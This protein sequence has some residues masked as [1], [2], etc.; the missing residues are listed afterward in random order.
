[1][2]NLN[3]LLILTMLFLF[4]ATLTS[5]V[6]D[7]ITVEGAIRKYLLYV[8]PSYTEGNDDEWP[9][10]LNLHF[11]R[12]N[13]PSQALLTRMHFLADTAKFI[14]V[15]P[16]GEQIDISDYT[17]SE[18]PQG[19]GWNLGGLFSEN[20]DV[21]FLE[22]MIDQLNSEYRINDSRIYAMGFS[23]GAHMTYF[24]AC[25][26]SEKLAA[27]AAVGGTQFVNV[28]EVSIPCEPV[29]TLPV[30]HI[31]GTEDYN[32]P[33]EGDNLFLG[34][35]G[36]VDF[37]LD[38]N[39]CESDIEVI[40][41]EDL[42]TTDQSTATAFKYKNCENEVE[43]WLYRID[44]GG[45]WWPGRED[46]PPGYQDLG[47]MNQDINASA[48]IWNFFSRH[49]L[50]TT[51][52]TNELNPAE[53]NL[54]SYPNPVSDQLTIEFELPTSARIQLDLYNPLG[55]RLANIADQFM[56]AGEHR[57]QWQSERQGIPAGLY[58]Y[59]LQVN[60][61]MVSRTVVLAR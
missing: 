7:S 38:H 28:G 46:I 60:D 21:A 26:L 52:T 39:N 59:R 54:R 12:G 4:S 29:S 37:W 22:Q 18:N 8:P 20:D 10:V 25:T 27:I 3:F 53:I 19:R 40:N 5:Q 61:R 30:L 43:V 6:I 42:D 11:F 32:V 48:E 24:L 17:D 50:G 33:Y 47:P 51:T 23:M 58:Y 34:A 2:R 36:S 41:F 49:S 13:P 14:V 44:G 16:E 31:H 35:E 15:Y 1:M 45:H 9:L 55:Q 57:L 56:G